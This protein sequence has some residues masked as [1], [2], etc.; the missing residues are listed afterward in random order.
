MKKIIAVFVSFMFV[1]I[2]LCTYSEYRNEKYNSLLKSV[3]CYTYSFEIPKGMY[4]SPEKLEYLKKAADENN[5][6]FLRVVSYYNDDTKESYTDNFLYLSTETQLFR[7]IPVSKGKILTPKDMKTQNFISTQQ[8]K[9]NSQIG[10]IEDFGGGHNYSVYPID[11]LIEQQTFSGRYKAEC[12]N[13]KD[14]EQFLESYVRYARTDSRVGST[15]YIEEME[16]TTNIQ[17]TGKNNVLF[18]FIF[19]MAL[20]L[21]TCI[22]Y[23][24]SQTKGISVMKLNGYTVKQ[25]K[26]TIFSLLYIK[27][28]LCVHI[29]VCIISLIIIH[30]ITIDFILELSIFNGIA[31]AISYLILDRICSIYAKY[32]KI[33][34]CIKGKKSLGIII[35]FNL[36]FK[37]IISIIIM[38]IAGSLLLK[39]DDVSLKQ[40]NLQN[41]KMASHYGVFYP[42]KTG[43]DT[44]QLRAGE[45]VLDLPTYQLYINY[46]EPTLKAIYVNSI[47]YR[48]DSIQ[49]TVGKSGYIRNMYVNT[50]YLDLFPIYDEDGKK[51]EIDNS[52]KNSIF[53]VPEKYRENEEQIFQYFSEFRQEFYE[54]HK[55]FYGQSDKVDASKIKIIYTQNDQ[56][57]FSFNIDVFPEN[58]NMIIDPIIMVM[59]SG[60]TLVPDASY[61]S[62]SNMKLFIPL[63]NM[64]AKATHN[65]IEEKLKEYDLDDNFPYLVKIDDFI[66]KNISEVETELLVLKAMIGVVIV[67]LVIVITQFIYLL[68][69]KNKFEMFLKKSLGYGY[70]QKYGSSYGI[71]IGTNFIEFVVSFF[72]YNNV[73]IWIFLFKIT[74]E[75]LLAMILIMY[76][77][78]K[79]VVKVLKEGI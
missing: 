36:C 14:F 12:A 48:M 39:L 23:L 1:L 34:Y 55:E 79:N 47:E 17:N 11:K 72:L 54:L 26:N 24:V 61:M 4:D 27:C 5:I 53:L 20:L 42:I 78:R 57:V 66:L 15:Y 7:R 75:I 37:V 62:S 70:F 69:Q 67:L 46:L 28:V 73:I 44:E 9:S 18:I 56:S 41:W 33:T 6:N 59:T 65:M 51:I 76:F 49:E 3:N 32:T 21:L 19:C 77:E 13:E 31:F 40:E 52:E 63:V 22:F 29:F 30:D 60:N 2:S 10:M 35:T 45:D 8:T 68:F 16:D 43:N 64:D 71:L 58:N 74:I 25:I 50:N 38:S